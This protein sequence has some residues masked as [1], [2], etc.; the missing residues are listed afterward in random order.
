MDSNNWIINAEQ[1]EII[2]PAAKNNFKC[3]KPRPER[4]YFFNKNK[5]SSHK[6][7]DPET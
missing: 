4:R 5:I 1:G 7:T 6:N 3:E 2:A